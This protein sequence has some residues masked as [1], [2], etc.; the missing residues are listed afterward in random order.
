MAIKLV[1]ALLLACSSARAQDP[2]LPQFDDLNPPPAAAEG[3]DGQQSGAD[4]EELLQIRDRLMTSLFFRGEFAD[5]IIEAG[6]QDQFVTTTGLETYADVKSALLEWIEKHPDEAA[7]AYFNIKRHGPAEEKGP[8]TVTEEWFKFNPVFLRLIAAVNKASKDSSIPEEEV[9]LIA[10]R[11]FQ[12]RETAAE[13]GAPVIAAG[14]GGAAPQGAASASALEYADYKLDPDAAGREARKIAGLLE[15]L[16]AAL[17]EDRDAAGLKLSGPAFELYKKFLVALSAL[18]GRRSITAAESKNLEELRRELRRKLAALTA[19]CAQNRLRARS[20]ALPA[21][22]PGA[23]LLLKEALELLSAF[24]ALS[25]SE[26]GDGG[27]RRLYA[28]QQAADFWTFKYSAYMRLALVKSRIGKVRFSCALDRIVYEVQAKL[29]PSAGYPRLK[30]ELGAEAADIAGALEGVAAGDYERAAKF[31]GGSG[32]AL[33]ARIEGIERKLAAVEACAKRNRRLQFLFW[34]AFL[35]PPGLEPA[36]YG[37]RA[38]NKL[39]R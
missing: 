38:G 23:G 15:G 30:K 4:S 32:D 9:S 22:A 37:A 33:F 7:K 16:K 5:S 10:A 26:D 8:K 12:G 11:L 20:S 27:A 17:E 35:N 14:R 29:T 3:A 31:A 1:F 19:H 36:R 13:A 25:G 34:D 28:L 18:K 21:G 24:G 39:L 2:G 6:L